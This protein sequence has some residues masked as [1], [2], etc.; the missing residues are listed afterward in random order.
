MNIAV[1]KFGAGEPETLIE[2]GDRHGLSLDVRERGHSSSPR[3]YVSFPNVEI[4]ERGM[5]ASYH[6]DGDTPDAAAADYARQLA[7]RRI[8]IDAYTDERVEIDVPNDFR[9]EAQQTGF[10]P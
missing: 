2:F 8:A 7:G 6:G 1:K 9:H 10:I 5:L 3:Y 4:M